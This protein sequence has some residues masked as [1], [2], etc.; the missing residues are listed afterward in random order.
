VSA[1]EWL[2]ALD[3]RVCRICSGN[4]G[5]GPIALG[6]YFSSGDDAPPGHPNCRCAIGPAWDVS[7]AN[8]TITATA[9]E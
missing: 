1:K 4:E 2:T 6:A 7:A 3:D 5:D 9:E 8:E